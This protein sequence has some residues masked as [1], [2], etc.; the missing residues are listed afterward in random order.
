MTYC[1]PAFGC[2]CSEK[3][4]RYEAA[5]RQL[6]AARHTPKTEEAALLQI[7]VEAIARK[8]LEPDTLDGVKGG[9]DERLA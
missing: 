4:R 1:H 3:I 7:E 2:D 6:A 9:G 8:A 5:L